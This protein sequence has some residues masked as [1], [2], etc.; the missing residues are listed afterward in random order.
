MGGYE[1]TWKLAVP[2]AALGLLTAVAGGCGGDDGTCDYLFADVPTQEDCGA[3]RVTPENPATGLQAE[4]DCGNAVYTPSTEG[5]Q[6]ISCQ[7]CADVDADFDGD[8]D[9]DL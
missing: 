9:D 2:V 4:F 3:G 5:C 8:V 6:L 1:T 7:V